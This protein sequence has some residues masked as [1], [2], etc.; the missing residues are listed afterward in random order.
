MFTDNM[1]PPDRHSLD[2]E[3]EKLEKSIVWIRAHQLAVESDEAD[4][5][6]DDSVELKVK[7]PPKMH[8]FDNGI[9][10]HDVAQGALGDC[11][12]LAAMACMAEFP[13]AIENCFCFVAF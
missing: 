1:F 9:N 7:A 11:W 3:D 5:K 8:L 13:G 10:P 6:E 2:L 4:V 12:L